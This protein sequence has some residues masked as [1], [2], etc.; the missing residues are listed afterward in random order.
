MVASLYLR[1]NY[2]CALRRVMMSEYIEKAFTGAK[3]YLGAIIAG[4]SYICFPD[5][6]Y[7]LSLMAV[8]AAAGMDIITKS[9]SIIVINGGY[10]NAV[11]T[12]KLF[13]KHLWEGTRRKIVSYTSIAILTGL[14]YR[15]IYLKE[16]GI[17]L[18]SFVYSVMFMREFQSNIENL[19]E[20]GADV[21]WLLLF[22]KKKN[23]DLM[24]EY[25]ESQEVK[26]DNDTRV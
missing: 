12:K 20:A 15:V 21:R 3:P 24:K 6:A 23:K 16:A 18:G 5:R 25:E 26:S 4:I 1:F 10:R 8:L 19:V 2:I 13:S 9:Y 22:A 7:F 14:S 11:K 17:V